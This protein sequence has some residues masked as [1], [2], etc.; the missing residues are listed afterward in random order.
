MSGT[1][2]RRASGVAKQRSWLAAWHGSRP[3]A[4]LRAN[5]F[6]R[7]LVAGG[8]NTLFGYAVFGASI[9]AGAP[10]WLALF[11]GMLAGTV[12][13][14]FTTGGYA[15]RTLAL[16][17]YPRFVGCYLLV[18]GVNLALIEFLSRWMDDKLLVQALL[19][20]PLALFSYFLMAR[21]VFANHE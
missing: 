20:V 15:F 19:L 18:Y 7:F 17:R 10:A 3:A 4:A 14:F 21:F 11:I 16:S 12:F 9:L 6:L 2:S 13:N 1:C 8:L 5:T